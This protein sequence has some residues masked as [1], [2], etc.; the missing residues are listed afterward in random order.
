M[1][2][3]YR[4]FLDHISNICTNMIQIY[5]ERI[6]LQVSQD[7]TAAKDHL[8]KL[9]ECH[10]VEKMIVYFRH[11]II[12]HIQ[13]WNEMFKLNCDAKLHYFVFGIGPVIT[14]ICQELL[15]SKQELTDG[16]YKRIVRGFHNTLCDLQTKLTVSVKTN[17]TLLLYCAVD[18]ATE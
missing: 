9:F 15:R 11:N 12:F 7:L 13:T 5:I 8:I 4:S 14:T 10:L 6:V 17:V 18:Y 1:H 16:G 3:C 2:N